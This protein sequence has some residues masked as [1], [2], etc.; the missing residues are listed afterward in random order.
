MPVRRILFPKIN[1][2]RINRRTSAFKVRR[3]RIAGAYA[4]DG[5]V[6]S[7]DAP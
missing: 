3:S 6:T 1:E 7:V 4:M 5:I 2:R